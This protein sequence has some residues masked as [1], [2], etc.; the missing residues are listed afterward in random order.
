MST[1]VEKARLWLERPLVG[2]R[3]GCSEAREAS[4]WTDGAVAV[5]ELGDDSDAGA[6][7]SDAIR[8]AEPTAATPSLRLC[9]PWTAFSYSEARRAAPAARLPRT[10]C[11]CRTCMARRARG[12]APW[13]ARG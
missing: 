3:R 6:H 10:F 13:M 12:T 5:V 7:E 2:H 8:A 9:T 4:P 1:C 11:V